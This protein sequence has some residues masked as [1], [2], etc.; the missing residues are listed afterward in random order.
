MNLLNQVIKSI[1][2]LRRYLISLLLIKTRTNVVYFE[3]YH[4]IIIVFAF[5]FLETIDN[6]FC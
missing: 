1:H 4:L 6:P 5:P 3:I 2:L